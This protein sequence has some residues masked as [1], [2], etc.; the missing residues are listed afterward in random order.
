MTFTEILGSFAISYFAGQL[1]AIKHLWKDNSLNSRLND[2]FDAA[3]KKFFINDYLRKNPPLR[4]SNLSAFGQYLANND[5]YDEE[6]RKF[7]DVLEMEYRA[8]EVCYNY[9]LEMKLENMA[10]DIREIKEALKKQHKSFNEL[11]DNLRNVDRFLAGDYHIS[12]NETAAILDW[13]GCEGLVKPVQRICMVT[14]EAGC[15]KTVVLADLLTEL[16]GRGIPVVGL[17]SDY[18]FDNNDSDIDKALNLNGVS[19]IQ[20]IEERASQGMTVLLIDQVDALSLSLTFKRKP[21]AEVQRVIT[22]LSFNKNVRIILSCREYDYKSERAFYRYNGCHQVLIKRLERDEVDKVLTDFH[23]STDGLSEEEYRFLQNPMNLSLYCRIVEKSTIKATQSSVYNAYWQQVLTTHANEKGFDSK[24]LHEYLERLVGFMIQEQVLSVNSQRMGMD[25]M[26]EQGFLLSEGYLAQSSDGSQIQFRHQTL[27]DYTYSRLFFESGKTVENDFAGVHQGLFV[28]SRLK[29]LLSYL[30]DVAPNQYI[31]NIRGI[32]MSD[33]Y[34]F[35]LKQLVITLIGSFPVLLSQEEHLLTEVILLDKKLSQVFVRTVYAL[36]PV[37]SLTRY[38]VQT[39]GFGHCEWIYAERVFD[40]IN[41]I[42]EQDAKAGLWIF[43][44]IDL[45]SLKG[46][47]QGALVRTLNY[48]PIKSSEVAEIIM[49]K[50]AVLDADDSNI[51]FHHFYANLAK[52]Q[53]ETVAERIKRYIAAKLSKWDKKNDWKFD[54]S[55]DLRDMNE[56]LEKVDAHLSL[57][58]G[59]ELVGVMAETSRLELEGYDISISSLYW[60][61]NRMNNP[62]HFPEIQLDKVLDQV[63]QEIKDSREDIAEILGR[64][65]EKDIDVFHVIAITGWMANLEK[66]KETAFHYLNCILQK[67]NLSSLLHYYQ[68]LLFGNVFM[69]LT[70]EQQAQLIDIV[71]KV[72]PEWEK[73]LRPGPIPKESRDKIPNTARG[74]TKG[75]LL[76]S[77]PED[78]LRENFREAW[79]ELEEIKRKGFE[80]TNDAPNK[81][82]SHHGWTTVSPSKLEHMSTDDR[83][84]LAEKYDSDIDHDWNRPTRVGLAWTMRDEVKKDPEQGFEVYMKLLDNGKADLYYVSTALSALQESGL[85]DIKMTELY[86]KL[87]KATGEDVNAAQSEVLIDICRSLDFYINNGSIAPKVLLDYVI[88]IAREAEDVDD[89][90]EA[91]VDYNT[92]INQVRGSAVDHLVR[93]VE[94]EPYSHD[95]FVVLNEIAEKAS[96]ATRCAA[97]FQMAVMMRSDKEKTLQLFL[98]LVHDYNKSLLRLP[99]HNMNPILYLISYKF[100]ALKDY[101]EHCIAEPSCHKENIVWLL[102]ATLRKKDGA[103]EM[104]FRMADASEEGRCTLVKETENYYSANCHDLMEKVLRRYMSYDEE[105]LGRIYDQIFEEYSGWPEDALTDYLNTFFESPVSKYCNHYVYE[106]LEK[107]AEKNPHQ[108]LYWLLAKYFRK[109]GN[110]REF[111]SMTEVLLAAYNRILVF[112]KNDK[113]IEDA[114][115]MLDDFLQS[116]DSG[117]IAQVSREIANV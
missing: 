4:Y 32:L 72:E 16:E 1:P 68:T 73:G 62:Y 102:V 53:P 105:Q 77:I 48:V 79:K 23:F 57:L 94:M 31:E 17:K 19:L 75:K 88:K 10:E 51:E 80:T 54:V 11:S 107:Y 7:I 35:H 111:D 39:G 15:G 108:T 96:V 81:V 34:R 27:F 100:D 71:R 60:H 95:I 69:L 74:F 112:D 9:I 50:V 5:E 14:G 65:S 33:T 38:I 45:S 36:G 46:V 66:Y 83:V 90:R 70:Q 6:T 98:H 84:R 49:K 22:K 2:C 55:S 20:M 56:A 41:Y 116:D 86:S 106:F 103:E 13:I 24:S 43:E 101:F 93:S 117:L 99:A 91:D 61:F 29:T 26:N 58:T 115:D 87:I 40:L 109:S 110:W 59:I 30:R 44:Q 85:S 28:R 47:R 52:Y 8:D 67:S 76:G 97:L 78:Y 63:E 25:M 89:K 114:M 104:L 82:E 12:R 92:G 64:L 21:L 42:F 113:V 3:M 18:L 37:K